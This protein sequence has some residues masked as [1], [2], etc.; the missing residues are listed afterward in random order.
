[1]P[2]WLAILV[3]VS[4]V[5]GLCF[6]AFGMWLASKEKHIKIG[7]AAAELSRTVA[8]Q[9]EMLEAAGRRIQ[10]LEAIVTSQVWDAV[11]DAE[12]PDGEKGRVLSRSRIELEGPEQ[13]PDDA[14]RAEQLARRLKV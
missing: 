8:A 14:E 6:A 13:E 7:T 10:N 2:T 11:N 1:M 12:L 9:Q 4:T 5:G 3:I